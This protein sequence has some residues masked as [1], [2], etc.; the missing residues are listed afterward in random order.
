M[1]QAHPVTTQLM[2]VMPL[3]LHSPAESLLFLPSWDLKS[4]GETNPTT[5]VKLLTHR[6]G[7]SAKAVSSGT[8]VITPWGYQGRLPGGSYIL[9]KSRPVNGTGQNK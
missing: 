3:Q 5:R 7:Q 1:C 8:S 2:G 4:R 6:K 9:A